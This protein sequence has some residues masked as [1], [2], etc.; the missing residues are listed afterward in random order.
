MMKFKIQSPSG[1]IFTDEFDSPQDFI[2]LQLADEALYPDNF[3]VLGLEIAGET[4]DFEGDLGAL[5]DYLTR[6]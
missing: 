1:A 3:K 6:G 2:S 4:I 5:Y